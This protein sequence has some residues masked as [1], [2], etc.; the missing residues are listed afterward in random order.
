MSRVLQLRIP[1]VG[2]TQYVTTVGVTY[3]ESP[4]K[5]SSL[6]EAFIWA[7]RELL[8]VLTSVTSATA[9]DTPSG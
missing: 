1:L 9:Q 8:E 3:S 2:R 7:M 5:K 6:T 4:I